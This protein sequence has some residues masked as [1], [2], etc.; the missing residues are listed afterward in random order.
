M[1]CHQGAHHKHILV[2]QTRF[3]FRFLMDLDLAQ[4]TWS[5]GE[6]EQPVSYSAWD[7]SPQQIPFIPISQSS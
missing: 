3:L 2:G 4:E 7:E 6:E 5:K 1:L